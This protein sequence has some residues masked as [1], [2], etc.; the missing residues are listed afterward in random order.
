MLRNPRSERELVADTHSG[1]KIRLVLGPQERCLPARPESSRGEEK[2]PK[3]KPGVLGVGVEDPPPVVQQ[4]IH[5]MRS[6]SLVPP[7]PEPFRSL[8]VEGGPGQDYANEAGLADQTPV[9]LAEV[10]V[11][12]RV[13]AH[14]FVVSGGQ[15]RASHLKVPLPCTQRILS[16][17]R[18][19]TSPATT[20]ER[21][22]S[23]KL[24]IPGRYIP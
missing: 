7:L 4:K 11:E 2:K 15:R 20:S 5:R 8:G 1:Q 24:L 18:S 3:T 14:L 17:G 13:P 23:R 10:L 12:I 9:A 6:G 19:R 22:G 16:S 21:S